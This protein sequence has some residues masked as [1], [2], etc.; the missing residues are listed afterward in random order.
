MSPEQNLGRALDVRTD[1]F[2]LG[3]TLYYMLTGEVAYEVRNRQELAIVFRDQ[4][5]KPPSRLNPD[6]GR[7]LDAVVMTMIAVD[8]DRRHADCQKVIS[9]LKGC[10][11]FD[12]PSPRPIRGRVSVLR[13]NRFVYAVMGAIVLATVAFAV[14]FGLP[15]AD[16][17][18]GK[19]V[20]RKEI[21]LPGVIKDWRRTLTGH[22]TSPDE[23]DLFLCRNTDMFVV[24]TDGEIIFR[25]TLV[26]D[27]ISSLGI[28]LV[29]DIDGDTR[30]EVF[31]HWSEG[32][33]LIVSV[34][35]QNRYELKRFTD[36]GTVY[37]GDAGK[38][39]ISQLIALQIIDVDGDGEKDLLARLDTGY[40]KT[41]RGLACFNMK[42]QKLL[43]RHLT[44][45]LMHAAVVI[46]IDN[47]GRNEV[48]FGSAATGNGNVAPDGTDDKTSYVC[49]LSNA[50]EPF[51][52]RQLGGY[53]SAAS[54][55]AADLDG[56]GRKELV[57]WVQGSVAW[58]R[59]GDCPI[60]I[61]GP[62]GEVL[63]QFLPPDKGQVLSCI[64]ADTNGDGKSQIIAT[65]HYGRVFFLDEKLRVATQSKAVETP[66]TYTDLRL[67]DCR[68]VTGD[69]SPELIFTSS[70]C[71][72]VSSDNPGY[73]TRPGNVYYHYNCRILV[74]DLS[75]KP[76]AEHVMA[77]RSKRQFTP[78]VRV[79]RFRPGQGM[80]ILVLYDKA[81]FLGFEPR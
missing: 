69:E 24:S 15:G 22:W 20:V 78:T 53:S 1:I 51:W 31:T 13:R 35:N 60:V 10:A 75:C 47:D 25:H 19:M 56:D 2:S 7:R 55:I 67:A 48:V 34:Q 73:A 12:G 39:L 63:S 16:V 29:L 71:K 66:H 26:K 37:T 5:P 80:E 33:N 70:E 8:P 54:P 40:G 6:V 68:N 9:A 42:T 3:M 52:V 11:D 21:E 79:G 44:G 36:K 17:S 43:W 81:T 64:A 27:D 23:T 49:A 77:E 65:D 45:G 61:L 72:I 50:G 28:G 41:P 59:E 32:E 62:K 30:P 46:D 76:I 38:N 58:H 74:T 4:K 18:V 14:I 57:G